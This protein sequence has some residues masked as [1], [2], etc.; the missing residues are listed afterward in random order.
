MIQVM[1][2]IHNNTTDN[3]QG[4]VKQKREKAWKTKKTK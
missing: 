3:T 1:I 2:I 4:E